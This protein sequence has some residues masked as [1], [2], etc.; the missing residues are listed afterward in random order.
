M[1]VRTWNLFHG[2]TVPPGRRRYVEEMVRLVT[3]DAPDVVCLQEVPPWALGRIGEW[4]GMQVYSEVAARPSIGPLPSTAE[5]GRVITDLHPGLLRSGFEGQANAILVAP[6]RPIL[7]RHVLTLNPLGFRLR[8]G[9]R[10][11]LP[12]VSQLAWGRE[13]RQCVAVR[14]EGGLVLANLH[15]TKA[16]NPRVPDAEIVRAAEWAAAL[17]GD[18]PAILA[19]DFNVDTARSV[20]IEQLDGY[21]KAGPGI[22][23]VV[24]RGASTGPYDRWTPA[25][26]RLGELALSDHAP[27]EV[28]VV[29]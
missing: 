29:T 7:A 2:N 9:R 20:T 11:G 4:S 25:R 1:I 22:D 6:E 16:R 3:Q 14:L 24:A 13:R 26:R 18:A 17:A 28:E 21:T 10:L 27:V 12:L 8:E 5:L 15:A 23:H 19:G